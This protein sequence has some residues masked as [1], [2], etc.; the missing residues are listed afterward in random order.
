MTEIA[1]KLKR[2]VKVALV[3][4]L[5]NAVVGRQQAE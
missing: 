4:R 3:C 2:I 5:A 1:V